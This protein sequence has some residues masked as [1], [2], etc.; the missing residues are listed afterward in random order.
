MHYAKNAQ[1]GFTLIE[2]LIVIGIL[3]VL[4]GIVLIAVNPARQF[5]QA[6]NAQRSSDANAILNA[7]GQYIVDNKGDLT[8]L[9]ITTTAQ[10]VSNTGADICNTLVPTYIPAFP[11]DPQSVTTGTGIA[12]ADCD[13]EAYDSEYQVV[14]DADG[15]I[16][17][18]APNTQDV[19]ENGTTPDI[20][21]TR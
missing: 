19:D 17:V 4:A 5:A 13:T 12:E 1:S 6:N 11:T 16:T 18:T 15:R 14:K 21:I 9:D 10:N 8:G 3:A 2:V 7:I 20:S